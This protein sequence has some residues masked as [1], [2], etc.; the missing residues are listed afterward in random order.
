MGVSGEARKEGFVR[1]RSALII[2]AAA[3]ALALLGTV[4]TV[5]AFPFGAAAACPSCYGLE[6]FADNTFIEQSASPQQR[7][8]IVTVLEQ[9]RGRVAAFYGELQTQPRILVCVSDGCY[10]RIRYVGSRGNAFGD[11]ALELSP[12]GLD[13][14]TAAHELSH[15]ELHH[16]IGLVRYFLGAIPSWFDEGLAVA[17]SDDR[18]YLA[19]AGAADRCKVRSDEALP[20]GIIEWGRAVGEYD[21]KQLYAKAACRVTDWMAAKGGK[22][23]VLRLVARVSQ[24]TSFDEAYGADHQASE[25]R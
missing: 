25:I 5:V 21:P 1:R 24:G 11:L 16:R 15:M 3:A 10:Q 2:G 17:V 20:T 7:A 9:G 22:A 18:R 23:A 8:R 19:P 13:P 4:G 14:V 12:R 6:R